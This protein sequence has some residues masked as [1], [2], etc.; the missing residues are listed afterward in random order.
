M[1]PGT[2][3]FSEYP[4]WMRWCAVAGIALIAALNLA[5]DYYHPLGFLFD[6]VIVVYFIRQWTP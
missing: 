6:A 4:R 3:K 5:L 1:A 2:M